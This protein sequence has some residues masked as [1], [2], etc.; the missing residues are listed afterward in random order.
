MKDAET[1]LL[2][3]E[4][5]TIDTL[6]ALVR[7][8]CPVDLSEQAW[9][10][11]GESRAIVEAMMQSGKPLYGIN[12][13]V[14]SQKDRRLHDDEVEAFNRAVIISEQT[15][16]PGPAFDEA[17][18]R[19]ALLVLLNNAA[20]GRLGIR[21]VLIR[22]LLEFFQ[23]GQMPE[24]RRN[25][26]TGSSDLGPLA[27]LSGAVLNLPPDPDD[28]MPFTLSAKEAV[29]LVNN[30]SFAIAHGAIVLNKVKHL[31]RAL[32]LATAVSLEA[33]RGNLSYL[34]P[35]MAACYRNQHQKQSLETIR[36]A[37][38]GS[39]LW[40][41]E[42]WR[43]LHDPLSFRFAM[44][45]NGAVRMAHDS[46]V[47]AFEDDLNCVCDNPVVSLELGEVVTGINMDSTPLTCA[48]DMLRQALAMA[49]SVSFERT[50]KVQNPAFSGLPAAFADP[51]RAESGFQNIILPHLTAARLAELHT[52]SAPVLLECSYGIVDG[53]IDVSG[54]AP[55]SVQRTEE[56]LDLG[57]QILANEI[58][59]AIWAIKIRDL[60]RE[61]LGA[62]VR[63]AYDQVGP[64]LPLGREGQEVFDFCPV[65]DVVKALVTNIGDPC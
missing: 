28:S 37:L 60:P 54:M 38:S 10:W 14:G 57:W 39:A 8:K 41:P 4:S 22:H 42:N 46:A 35:E 29:S 20:T 62:E 19:A 2:D 23:T 45:V 59:I 9:N 56:V 1:T 49:V 17:V 51:A 48:M 30:N 6:V 33:H 3:G 13:G 43:Q 27:Q 64:L 11:V 21:P 32:D 7:G 34:R 40:K 52:L 24:I 47:Q 65:I 61:G 53:A 63:N 18:V 58:L 16:F 36:A 31:L 15:G 44:R 55:L 26:S 12:T 50:M 5:L 25:I